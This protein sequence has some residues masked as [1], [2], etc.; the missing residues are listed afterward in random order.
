M[1]GKVVREL[2]M[3]RIVLFYQGHDK[4]LRDVSGYHDPVTK[5]FVDKTQKLRRKLKI[6]SSCFAR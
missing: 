3:R 4:T 5:D 6:Q 2:A 1:V